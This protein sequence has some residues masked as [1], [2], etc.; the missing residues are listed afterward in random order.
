VRDPAPALSTVFPAAD[1][2]R[3]ERT[4]ARAAFPRLAKIVPAGT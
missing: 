2:H 4:N 3:I 1:R